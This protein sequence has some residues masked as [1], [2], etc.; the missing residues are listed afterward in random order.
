MRSIILAFCLL[1]S[2]RFVYFESIENRRRYCSARQRSCKVEWKALSTLLKIKM[3]LLSGD[4][5]NYLF[6][7]L[8]SNFRSAYPS[9]VWRLFITFTSITLY[10]ASDEARANLKVVENEVN[11]A[12]RKIWRSK[13]NKVIIIL[14]Q[15]KPILNR[16][17]ETVIIIGIRWR[18]NQKH[19]RTMNE[20]T[21]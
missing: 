20:C 7:T 2:R 4:N 21:V 5:R 19:I 17:I 9:I 6:L 10:Q 8:L 16:R 13:L 18:I 1:F 14:D 12:F 3:N 15:G 11:E